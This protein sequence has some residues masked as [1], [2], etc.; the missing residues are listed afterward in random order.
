MAKKKEPIEI[1]VRT[2]LPGSVVTTLGFLIEAAWPGASL[3]SPA[4]GS[5][6]I[7]FRIPDKTPRSVAPAEASA[8]AVAP[9]PEGDLSVY[10]LGPEG[11]R[12]ATP[13][14]LVDILLP[15]LLAAFQE[16]PDAANYLEIPV[17]D[18]KARRT[19]LLTLC[20]SADQTPHQ[21]RALAEDNLR[22]A[23][24]DISTAHMRA[25]QR[26]L[27]VPHGES[28]DTFSAGVKAAMNAVRELNFG[29]R[30]LDE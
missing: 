1:S 29:R 28:P 9:S 4:I 20:R 13:V 12:I 23:R 15:S 26:L 21:L 24:D 17:R 14:E 16:Y 8:M 11:I 19:Y 25:L 3:V 10:G 5:H 2:P 7:I 6:E 27:M 22:Q 18:P 30:E